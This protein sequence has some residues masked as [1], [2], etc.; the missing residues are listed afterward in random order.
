MVRADIRTLL[1]NAVYDILFSD[2][3]DDV[4]N[5]S[6][7]TS[8]VVVSAASRCLKTINDEVDL[9]SKLPGNMSARFRVGTSLA[10]ACKVNRVLSRDLHDRHVWS[11]EC[12]CVIEFGV[13]I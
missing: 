2:I 12:K 8:E 10:D 3:P 9:P 7:F 13:P 6:V 4:T 5:L 11:C 1:Q